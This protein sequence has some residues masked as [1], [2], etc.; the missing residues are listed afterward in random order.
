MTARGREVR[1]F[2]ASSLVH[3]R[4]VH[5]LD[6]HRLC[7]WDWTTLSWLA[8]VLAIAVHSVPN[9]QHGRGTPTC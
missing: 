2:A 6:F 3:D 1:E 8:P 7:V 4:H 5:L 9:A